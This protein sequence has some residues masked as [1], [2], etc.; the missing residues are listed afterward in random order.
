MCAKQVLDAA[1]FHVLG[2]C[3]VMAVLASS[4]LAGASLQGLGWLPGDRGSAGWG[5]SAD[6][7]V[8]VGESI[9]DSRR[10]AFRWT[11]S[12]GMQGLGHLPGGDFESRALGASQDG[13]VVVGEG[14]SVS[15]WE[16]FRWTASSGMQSLGVPEGYINSQ[17]LSVS[18]EGSVVIGNCWGYDSSR[19]T[20]FVWTK[21]GGFAMLLSR[22]GYPFRAS[23]ISRDGSVVIGRSGCGT[24]WQG[25][26]NL[27]PLGWLPGDDYSDARGVSGDGSVVVGDSFSLAMGESP[28]PF[29]WTASGGMEDLGLPPGFVSARPYAAS[30]DG[31]V[32]VGCGSLQ[33]WAQAWI[34]DPAHG[35]C[36]LQDALVKDYGLDL[37]GWA[38]NFAL[39]ISDDGRTIVGSGGTPLT[40]C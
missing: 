23:D 32:V 3:L 21:T 2:V 25:Y 34:W 26:R 28:R 35:V 9:S 20:G 30:S 17:A 11:A 33:G 13:S 16:A 12:G 7:S 15:G 19:A 29:R 24:G 37:S 39:D 4:A 14:R 18:G 5:V 22:E 40:S 38:L 31:S 8:V 6:G 27:E 10:E 1:R 36:D